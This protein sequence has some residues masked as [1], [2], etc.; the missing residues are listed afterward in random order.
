MGVNEIWANRLVAGTQMWNKVPASRK[1][2]I[3]EIL[4]QR[5]ADGKISAERFVEITGEP[6]DIN[7]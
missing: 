1:E 5:V 4:A 7:M 3:K 6:L 2:T